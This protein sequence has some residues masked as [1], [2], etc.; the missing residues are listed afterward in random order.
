MITYGLIR[1]GETEWNKLGKLQGQLNTSLTDAGRSQAH[2]L[3]RRLLAVDWD[4]M[5]AS[6][7]DRA[8]ETARIIAEESGIPLIG[9]DDRLRERTFGELEGTT[10]EERV[11]RWGENW[12]ALDL[13]VEDDGSVFERWTR[14]TTDLRL[15]HPSARRILFVTHGSYIGSVLTKLGLE[16]PGGYLTNASLTLIHDQNGE[17]SCSLY[18][19]TS[20][21]K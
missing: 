18:S 4:M 19:C 15:R 3:G 13:G 8:A 14:L 9:V 20:H 5:L 16:K 11:N 10:L 12:K 2:S 7:L 17:W 6:D 21:L 1:H